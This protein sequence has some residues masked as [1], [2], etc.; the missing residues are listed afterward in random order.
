MN[1][2]NQGKGERMNKNSTGL[3]VLMKT[4]ERVCPFYD[5]GDT[6]LGMLS[7]AI[8]K[9]LPEIA[10]AEG[11]V[12]VDNGIDESICGNYTIDKLLSH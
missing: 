7:E 8:L 4:I 1:L 6:T 12:K 9:S 11:Y 10:K 2:S 3:E 5:L